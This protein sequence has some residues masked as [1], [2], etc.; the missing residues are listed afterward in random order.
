MD[1]TT[2]SRGEPK[3]V[4]IQTF[5]CQMNDYDSA[6]MVEQLRGENYIPVDSPRDADLILV[7]TCAI[8]EKSEHKVYSLL[9]S[10]GAIKQSR[11][12]VVIGV[13]GCVSQQ[14][15]DEILKRVRSVDMVF[16]TDNLFEL[17]EM[18]RDV[19]GGKRVVRTAWH[20]RK[21]K[22]ANFIPAFGQGVEGLP[23][24]A[25][26]VKAGLVITKGCNNFCTFCVVPYTR[27]R[28]VS[29][30]P[31]N[32][33]AEA[34]AL[35]ENG[36]R[37]ITLLG[38]NVNSYKTGSA[39]FVDLLEQLDA[40]EGLAR[41]R[42][43]SPHPKDFGEELAAAHA[44][45]PKLCE[46]IHLPVQSG[47]NRILKAMRRNHTIESYLDKVTLIREK[48]PNMA[49]STDIIVGF[50]GEG[51][52]DF[53]DTLSLMRQARFDHLYAFKFSPRS[54]TPA[55]G[56]RHQVPEGVRAERLARLFELHE[57]IRKER[58]EALIGTGQEVLV[59]GLHP[60]DTG[61][62]TGRTRGN[63]PVTIPGRSA[64]PGELVPVTIV[65]LR[66]QS[67]VGR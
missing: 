37:E 22:V 5:G 53:E 59:E 63:K 29:R 3:G 28:E 12:E 15:G 34:R 65:A 61:A 47:S 9:G 33:L 56:Y 35:V 57:V 38:Q 48:V 67:L 66:H 24:A 21:R 16:G 45:L 32:I 43:T 44:R 62:V 58:S 13:G 6:K 10:L 1:P 50:P 23:D 2:T 52:Q 55:A 64:E 14:R 39:R 54:D 18:L 11:P 42:Y 19:A 51:D 36:T 31:D 41:I 40:I 4:Y 17:P 27:G 46:H 60:R 30:E 7:N 8:R 26:P 20:D 25:P 49:L